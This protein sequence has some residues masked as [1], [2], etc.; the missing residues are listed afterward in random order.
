MVLTKVLETSLQGSLLIIVMILCSFTV[1][2]NIQSKYKKLLWLFIALRFLFFIQ[3][4]IFPNFIEIPIENYIETERDTVIRE[5]ISERKQ[6]LYEQGM[7]E[8]KK[9]DM[10]LY[11]KQYC[12]EWEILE[13]IYITGVIILL[14]YYFVNYYIFLYKIKR[15]GKKCEN[16]ELIGITNEILEELKIKKIAAYYMGKF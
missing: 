1:L 4:D 10:I 16:K 15:Y 2:R 6:L 9:D 5:Q 12:N 7:M 13:K 3:I 11:K 14:L 8:V